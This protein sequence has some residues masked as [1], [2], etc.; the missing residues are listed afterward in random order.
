MKITY[1][2]LTFVVNKLDR[3]KY[4]ESKTPYSTICYSL[5]LILRRYIEYKNEKLTTNFLH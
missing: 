2:L 5:E 4:L 3:L 1:I